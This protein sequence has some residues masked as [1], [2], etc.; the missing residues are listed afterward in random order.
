M[1]PAEEIRAAADAA[2]IVPFPAAKRATH[3]TLAQLLDAD[4]PEPTYAV[5]ELVQKGLTILA[6]RPK[7]GKSWLVLDLALAISTNKKAMGTF[8]CEQGDVLMLALEDGLPRLRS[9]FAK[10]GAKR[11]SQLDIHTE[12]ARGKDGVDTIRRWHDAHQATGRMVVV[13][14]ITRMRPPSTPNR[15]A[16]QADAEALEPLQRLAVERGIAVLA[17]G[18]T[19]KAEADD[20]LDTVGGTSGLTGTADAVLVLRRERG[21]ADA[22]LYGTGRDIREFEKPLRFDEQSGR[23]SVLDMSAAEAKAG[24][25]Q[26]EIVA[27][28]RR[29]GCG[30]TISQ[31]AS[32]TD[33]SKQAVYDALDRLEGKGL[34]QKAGKN[35]WALPKGW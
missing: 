28:L 22:V 4:F 31:I 23:W 14:T 32:A 35:L 29:I 9:R 1:R 33:H 27:V 15:N 6:G 5:A 19:R 18:H 20:W 17:V 34:V 24:N 25:F 11:T 21:Q 8:D 3:M 26:S 12:W 13:D 10:L 7:L 2:K 30:L 16:Y